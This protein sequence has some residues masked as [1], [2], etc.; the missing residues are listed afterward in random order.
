MKLSTFKEHLQTVLEVSFLKP[1]GTLIPAHF[2]I[3]EVGQVD[4]KFIDCGGKVR[5]EQS[6]SLQLWES[7]DIW[8]RLEPNKLLKIIELSEQKLGIQDSEIEVEYQAETIGKFG[9]DF[10]NN[11]F[12]LVS[13]NTTCLAQDNCGTSV[14]AD[15]AKKKIHSFIQVASSCCAPNSGYC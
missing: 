4:K 3:T 14:I 1:D 8:H 10:Q 6:V 7:V 15:K 5:H 11:Q 12:Q 9:V 13:K 2:H